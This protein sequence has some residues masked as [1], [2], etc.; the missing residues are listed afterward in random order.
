MKNISKTSIF[1]FILVLIGIGLLTGAYFVNKDSKEFKK[2]PRLPS[3]PFLKSTVLVA[4]KK[5][6]SITL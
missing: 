6:M 2:I 5:C 1:C 4:P 3:L